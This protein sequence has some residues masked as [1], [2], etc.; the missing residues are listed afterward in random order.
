MP[1]M[2]IIEIFMHLIQSPLKPI[3]LQPLDHVCKIKHTDKS[4]PDWAVNN[5]TSCSTPYLIAL[6][7]FRGPLQTSS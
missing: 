4:L 5:Y 2:W 3:S 7:S 6:I 1:V